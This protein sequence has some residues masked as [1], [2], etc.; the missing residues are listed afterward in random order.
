MYFQFCMKYTGNSYHFYMF[1]PCDVISHSPKPWY[2][3]NGWI[4]LHVVFCFRLVL[5]TC[6]YPGN[7]NMGS[8][9]R[10]SSPLMFKNIQTVAVFIK[11]R[12]YVPA[13][14][15]LWQYNLRIYVE[16]NSI[17]SRKDGTMYL[18]KNCIGWGFIFV[19]IKASFYE[20]HVFMYFGIF[21][22][23]IFVVF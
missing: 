12:E 19:E 9:G 16:N 21:F 8:S 10:E 1:V 2:F 7:K 22:V 20:N 13:F 18:L 5:M 23:Q 17:C 15:R 4:F 3:E 6:F 14:S 11:K